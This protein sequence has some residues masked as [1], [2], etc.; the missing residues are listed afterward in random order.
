M[1]GLINKNSAFITMAIS[2]STLFSEFTRPLKKGWVESG[3]LNLVYI[4]SLL[5]CINIVVIAAGC[6]MSLGKK[7]LQKLGTAISPV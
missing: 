2:Y 5:V 3:T 6:C 4:S 7:R 1:S